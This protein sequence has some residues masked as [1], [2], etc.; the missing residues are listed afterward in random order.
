MKPLRLKLTWFLM[1]ATLAIASQANAQAWVENYQAALD[2]AAKNEWAAARDA[3]Q[4]AAMVRAEDQSDPTSLPGSITEPVFWRKRAPYS[5]NFGA[6]YAAFQMAK[7]AAEQNEKNRLLALVTTEIEALLAKN[8][9]SAEAVSIARQA[10]TMLGNT[11]AAAKLETDHKPNNWQIDTAFMA[12]EDIVASTPRDATGQTSAPPKNNNNE[13]TIR[14]RTGDGQTTTTTNNT[15]NNTGNNATTGTIR[16]EDIVLIDI[17]AQ[18]LETYKSLLPKITV[19][20][21]SDKFAILIGNSETKLADHAVPY[22]TNDVAKLQAALVDSAGYLPE[23][24]VTVNNATSQGI[25]D[26][27]KALADRLPENAKV[28]VYFTGVAV[29]V[30]GRDYLTGTDTE[31]ATDVARMVPKN[32][33]YGAFFAKG[34]QIFAFYQADRSMVDGNYFGRERPPVGRISETHATVAGAKI[35]SIIKEGQP[36]GLYTDAMVSVLREFLTNKVQV[37]DFCWQVFY[38]IRQGDSNFSGGGSYQTPTLPNLTQMAAD[39]AAF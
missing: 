10:Y 35:N 27:V 3:F 1:A 34:A 32:E 38:R 21:L 13:G 16:G 6:A 39:S 7:S 11:E 19:P 20:A 17:K 24:I 18:D 26:A 8:Q 22:A 30:D 9:K 31:F 15:S 14:I 37:M 23:N 29:G 5:P 4:Q 25:R 28:L 33:V 12:K 2:A 36:I